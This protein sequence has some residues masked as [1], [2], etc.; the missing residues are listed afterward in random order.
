MA[1]KFPVCAVEGATLIE[2]KTYLLFDEIWVV[3]LDKETAFERVVIRNPDLDENDI[4]QRIARQLH[5]RSRIHH[6]TFRYDGADSWD[7][8]NKVEID[9][10]MSQ[11]F[12]NLNI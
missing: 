1:S 5:D 10:R 4:K 12:R 9:K 8:V 11:V 6:A 3:T 2:S 7:K